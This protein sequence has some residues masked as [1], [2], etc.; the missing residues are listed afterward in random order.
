MDDPAQ[1]DAL[2]ALILTTP[3]FDPDTLPAWLVAECRLSLESSGYL[4]G[5][6]VDREQAVSELT[7]IRTQPEYDVE[8]VAAPPATRT[9]MDTGRGSLDTT[10]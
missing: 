1:P 6:D 4:H 7:R 10:V 2:L 3:G 5:G 9:M 8:S